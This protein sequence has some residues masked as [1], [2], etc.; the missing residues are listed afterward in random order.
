MLRAVDP[1][2]LEHAEAARAGGAVTTMAYRA[3]R[4]H[5]PVVSQVALVV[6]AVELI[7]LWVTRSEQPLNHPDFR[8]SRRV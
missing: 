3:H 2:T 1:L 8:G 4:A 7:F 6:A 5:Q